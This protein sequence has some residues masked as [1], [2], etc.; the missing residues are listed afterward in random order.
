MN[1]LLLTFTLIYDIFV[2]VGTFV[3]AHSNQ[4]DDAMFNMTPSKMTDDQVNKLVE[5]FRAQVTKHASEI[6]SEA[7]QVALGTKGLAV[8]MFAPF[9]KRAEAVSGMIFRRTT[10]DLSSSAQNAIKATGRAMHLNDSVVATM[11]RGVSTEVDV[12]FFR[13]GCYVSCA[14]LLKEYELRGLEPA[15]PFSLAAVNQTDPAFADSRPNGT[16]WTDT[17]GNFCYALFNRWDGERGVLVRR[18]GGD[19][20]DGCWFAGVRKST[21]V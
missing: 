18:L 19:W 16:Q 7:A 21:Q 3:P 6:S 2:T 17:K 15:D 12:H 9:R 20:P 14:D 1:S 10:V 13:L 4:G 5:Q 11:P 8:E